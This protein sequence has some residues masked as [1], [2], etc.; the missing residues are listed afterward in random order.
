MRRFLAPAIAVTAAVAFAALIVFGVANTS[1]DRS[2]D[3]AVAAGTLPMAPSAST[4]L[5]RIG[6]PGETTLA[7]LRG[8]V[9]VL[10]I[11]A[12]WCPPCREESPLLERTWRRIGKQGATVLG[13][14][15]NDTER[16]A[17]TFIDRSG[18]TYPQ[19]R[20]VDGSFAKSYGTKGLPET[21][22]IDRSG[23]IS[24]MR[25]GA[26]DA[27]FLDKALAPL[28]GKGVEG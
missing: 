13:V 27:A 17:Q 4:P 7:S 3:Q 28:L 23:R 18:L 22:V 24:S 11:W 25:R 19:A 14:T 6:A 15:W 10:N 8:K 16:D 9:V 2:L 20:D 21:F 26:V 1:E 12:S 5:P